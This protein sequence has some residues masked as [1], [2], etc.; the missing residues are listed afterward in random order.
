MSVVMCHPMYVLSLIDA[1]SLPSTTL[2]CRCCPV[3]GDVAPNR[4]D[5]RAGVHRFSGLFFNVNHPF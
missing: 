5:G 1:R 4:G 3:Y 2:K